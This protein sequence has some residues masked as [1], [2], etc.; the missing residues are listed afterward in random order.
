MNPL[1][2]IT[3]NFK[4]TMVVGAVAIGAMFLLANAGSGNSSQKS[5]ALSGVKRSRKKAKT[6]RV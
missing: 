5:P 6:I 4:T 1:S 2:L 3:G